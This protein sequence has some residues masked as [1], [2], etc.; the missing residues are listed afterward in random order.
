MTFVFSIGRGVPV[1][2][3]PGGGHGP[4]AA[5]SGARSR[6][7]P[8]AHSA[9]LLHTPLRLPG[10]KRLQGTVKPSRRFLL[11]KFLGSM[12][13]GVAIILEKK[14]FGF[15][16]LCTILFYLIVGVSELFQPVFSRRVQSAHDPRGTQGRQSLC[17]KHPQPVL[18]AP[19]QCA[20]IS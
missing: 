1:H 8:R 12:K 3:G 19:G 9:G 5:A 10:G 2:A 15:I 4:G 7:Y 20:P 17:R 16:Q 11:K 18:P 6:L 14:L 13:I